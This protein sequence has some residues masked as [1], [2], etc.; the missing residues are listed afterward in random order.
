MNNKL[1]QMHKQL[2][3]NLKFLTQDKQFKGERLKDRCEE[4]N[5][6]FRT[7]EELKYEMRS[8]PKLSTLIA[9]EEMFNVTIDE[10]VNTDLSK[11]K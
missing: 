1:N 6:S 5:I 8:N 2:S 9:L 7:V 11:K 4:C 10:L 3:D